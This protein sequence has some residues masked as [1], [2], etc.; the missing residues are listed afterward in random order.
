MRS[1][2][3]SLAPPTQ[4]VVICSV[5]R[6]Y[7]FIVAGAGIIGLTVARELAG[8]RLGTVCVLEKERTVG[9]HASGRNSGVVH[10]GLYYPSGSLKSKVCVEG[11]KRLAAYAAEKGIAFHRTGKVVVAST[12]SKARLIEPL[13]RQAVANGARVELVDE[14]KLR[15]IE[16][17]ARTCGTG[18]L[19]SGHG[20]D[21]LKRRVGG[22]T[23]GSLVVGG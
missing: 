23:D 14:K 5:A 6:R 13:Y 4:T 11:S 17:E 10:A 9:M 21:R 1:R 8:R 3:F 19:F 16:P 7:D 18:H 12:P 15:E 2:I 22:L 20:G